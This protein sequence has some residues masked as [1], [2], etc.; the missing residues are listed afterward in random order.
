MNN[1]LIS[2]FSALIFTQGSAVGGETGHTVQ[3]RAARKL[4]QLYVCSKHFSESGFTSAERN[5]CLDSFTIP[6]VCTVVSH[7]YATRHCEEPP[8][9][10][11]SSEKDLHVLAH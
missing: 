4:P 1:S 5:T 3:C 11:L 10:S 6:Y 8:L 7:T 9:N 2:V